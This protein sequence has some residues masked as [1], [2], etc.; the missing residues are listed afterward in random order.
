MFITVHV[1]YES[2]MPF[3]TSGSMAYSTFNCK[4]M[5]R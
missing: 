3:Y 4:Q 5:K 2:S 1:S